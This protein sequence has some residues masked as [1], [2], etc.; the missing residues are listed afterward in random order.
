[1]WV[2]TWVDWPNS[3]STV[4]SSSPKVATQISP[5]FYDFNQNGN[6]TSGPPALAYGDSNPT[7]DQVAQQVH[8]AGMLLVPLV[9]AGATNLNDGADQGIQNI[10]NDSTTQNNFIT[11]MV[12]EAQSRHYD[13]WNLDW[14]VGPTTTNSQYGAKFVGFLAAF[15]KA[16]HAQNMILTIDVAQWYINQCGNDALVDLSQIGP[17][18]DYAIMEDY[19]ADY[20]TPLSSCPGGPV[21]SGCASFGDLMNL[22]CNVTPSSA[23]SIG[24][25]AEPG[26]TVNQGGAL[27]GTGPILGQAL[28]AVSAAGFRAIAV[29]PDGSPFLDSTG[30]PNGQTWMSMLG[31]WLNQ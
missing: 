19:V 6:Y 23:V 7:I 24:L 4:T 11:A 30:V 26:G 13:G 27:E 9:Y 18:V 8:A 5:D 22:M 28:S 10:L 17:V 20:G 1:M 29:W 12:S 16:L 14:E 3:L 15:K 21:Q 25:L 31:Q 2:P